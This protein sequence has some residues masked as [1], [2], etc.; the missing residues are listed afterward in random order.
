MTQKERKIRLFINRGKKVNSYFLH[1]HISVELF[2]L[3]ALFSL[4]FYFFN[5]Q[6]VS[7]M[8]DL[9]EK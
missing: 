8:S 7:S 9:D 6:K 2:K 4:S 5:L 1:Q 3:R